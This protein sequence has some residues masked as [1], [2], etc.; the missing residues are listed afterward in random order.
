MSVPT[1][2][3]SAPLRA[4]FFATGDI[5]RPAFA[6][7]R[8]RPD[9]IMLGLVSQPDKP[10]GRHQ[11]LT[12]PAIKTDALAAGVTVWQPEKARDLIPLLA[13]LDADIFLVM[14][15]GQILPQALMDLPRRACWNLHASLLP[16]HRGASPIQAALLAGDPATGVTVM[17]MAR[18]LDAGDIVLAE[19]TALQPGETGGELH[20]RL[21]ELAPVAMNRALDALANGTA[22]RT[23][24]DA[25]RATVLGKLERADGKL[26]WSQ[27]A[28]MLA[29]MIPA[30]APWPGTFTRDPAGKILKI[31]PPVE[32]AARGDAADALPGTI[33]AAD[34]AGLIVACG[35][36]ALRI[37]CL[38]PEGKRRMA[39][40]DFL[41]GHHL[42]VGTTRLDEA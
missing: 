6:A 28:A 5:A 3:P 8:A 15:Y 23:P 24:Q 1:T 41:R 29:R 38:Q 16:R 39:A 18:A 11:I 2:C 30:F 33:L 37:T 22:T 19:S 42:A 7:M 21:A 31:H 4:V 34:A 12:P 25:A 26:D 40:A 10:V 20:D 13:A 36:G 17:H 14:A 35:D 32:V 27:P 9:I